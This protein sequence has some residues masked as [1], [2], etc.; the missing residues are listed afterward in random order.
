MTEHICQKNE[1]CILRNMNKVMFK[2]RLDIIFVFIFCSLLALPALFMNYSNGI[3]SSENRVLASF[4]KTVVDGKINDKFTDEFTEWFRDHMGLRDQLIGTYAQIQFKVFDRTLNYSD[5]YIGQKGD[6][7]G[8]TSEMVIDYQHL[9]RRNEEELASLANSY[10]LIS[11]WLSQRDVQFYYVQCYDKHS[12]I[13]SDRMKNGLN[14]INKESKTDQL[15]HYLLDNTT[16]PVISL[17]E[18]MLNTKDEYRAYSKWGDPWHWSQR[19]GIIAYREIMQRFNQ[20]NSGAFQILEDSDFDISYTDQGMIIGSSVHCVDELEDFRVKNPCA[21][22]DD[23]VDMGQF[24][25][26]NRNHV[27]KNPNAKSDKKILIIGDSYIHTYI[28]NY[29]AES[30]QETWGIRLEY[31]TDID[32]AVEMADPDIVIIERAERVD[33]DYLISRFASKLNQK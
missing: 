15:I 31:I 22:I 10:Q 4:P 14:S 7:I 12:I 8:L 9:N 19:G 24:A 18:C 17:K 1:E 32:K 5:L 3:S 21:Y 29:I 26:D 28:I 11:D 30:F 16:V 13:N 23:T 33:C 25:C 20:D 6:L 2:R 27:W